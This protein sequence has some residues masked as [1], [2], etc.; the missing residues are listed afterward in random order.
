MA[1]ER[2]CGTAFF[3]EDGILVGEVLVPRQ[4][5]Q[6]REARTHPSWSSSDVDDFIAS[7][8]VHGPVLRTAREAVNYG[9]T[10]SV[11]GA[12]RTPGFAWKHSRSLHGAGLSFLAGGVFGWTFGHEI[13]NRS[14]QLCRVDTMAAQTKLLEWWVRKAEGQSY[15]VSLLPLL[16]N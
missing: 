5:F 12:V 10:G 13:A 3:T 9:L 6:V 16:Q 14:L 1:Q 7:V 2:Q 11:L 8:P 15:N 4:L